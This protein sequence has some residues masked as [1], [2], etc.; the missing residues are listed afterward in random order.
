MRFR[1]KP[2]V[3]AMIIIGLT[4]LVAERTSL[5]QPGPPP[6]LEPYPDSGPVQSQVQERLTIDTLRL[7]HARGFER[8]GLDRKSGHTLRLETTIRHLRVSMRQTAS[9]QR[10]R[11]I[12]NWTLRESRSSRHHLPAVSH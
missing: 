3:T 11:R 12:L 2:A 10:V 5:S 9:P 1:F 4:T 7:E 8:A 6:C